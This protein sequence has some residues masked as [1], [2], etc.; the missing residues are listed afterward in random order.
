MYFINILKDILLQ[1][2]TF[3]KQMSVEK[4]FFNAIIFA[5]LCSLVPGTILIREQLTWEAL[6]FFLA[7]FLFVFIMRLFIDSAVLHGLFKVL[8]GEAIYQ[9]S[10]LVLSYSYAANLFVTIPVLAIELEIT[11][12]D[13]SFIFTLYGAYLIARGGQLIHKLNFGKSAFAAF[14]WEFWYLV[15]SFVLLT[16]VETPYSTGISL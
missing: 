11:P 10:L 14:L 7:G 15:T 12:V 5:L 4:D 1:P 9:K 2:S 16:F 8:G 3:F 13:F 6:P